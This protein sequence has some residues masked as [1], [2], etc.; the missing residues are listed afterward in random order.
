[1]NRL[2]AERL[3]A[4]LDSI[5]FPSLHLERVEALSKLLHLPKFKAEA[6][7]QGAFTPD[8]NLLDLLADEFEVSVS[9]LMGKD[10]NKEAH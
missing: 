10:K 3:N 4:E 1:M 7:L 8:P 5:G 2:F 6:L 9:W